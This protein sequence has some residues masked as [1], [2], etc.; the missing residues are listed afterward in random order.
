MY[1]PRKLVEKLADYPFEGEVFKGPKDFDAYLTINY[2]DY[3]QLPPE[4]E[5]E[6]RHQIVEMD[7]GP[8][9]ECP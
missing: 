9:E 5:R 1:Y 2:G 6:N 7:F 4:E 8:E 3:M